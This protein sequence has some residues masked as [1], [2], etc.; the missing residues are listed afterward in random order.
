[1]PSSTPQRVQLT[2]PLLDV[3]NAHIKTRP[4]RPKANAGRSPLGG[5]ASAKN[6][7]PVGR[8]YSRPSPEGVPTIQELRL[9]LVQGRKANLP[10]GNTTPGRKSH[11]DGQDTAKPLGSRASRRSKLLTPTR[12]RFSQ[13]IEPDV[14]V[15]VAVSPTFTGNE[16]PTV[17]ES[18]TNPV[19]FVA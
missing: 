1:M 15:D 4:I 6:L 12:L 7:R 8:R 19:R 16:C 11:M 3:T 18:L 5:I 2:T 9:R 14:D 10:Q 17:S 13:I